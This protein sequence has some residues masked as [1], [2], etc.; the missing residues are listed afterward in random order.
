MQANINIQ[1]WEGGG[2]ILLNIKN[3]NAFTCIQMHTKL[4]V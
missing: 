1:Q 2:Y 4:H 3:K